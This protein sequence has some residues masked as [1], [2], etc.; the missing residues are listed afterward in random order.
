MVEVEV[1][2]YDD[3]SVSWDVEMADSEHDRLTFGWC[4]V[5]YIDDGGGGLS[6]LEY[7]QNLDVWV[8][9]NVCAEGDQEI[10]AFF[11]I[12]ECSGSRWVS[13]RDSG[14]NGDP[15]L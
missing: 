7:V 3:R 2:G 8:F 11:N 1:A 13:W 12:G 5:V 9:N 6:R 14:C 15:S 4:I 10:W